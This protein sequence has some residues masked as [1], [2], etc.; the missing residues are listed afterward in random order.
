MRIFECLLASGCCILTMLGDN[1]S[2]KVKH[3]KQRADDVSQVAHLIL[4]ENL[5]VKSWTVG[6]KKYLYLSYKEQGFSRIDRIINRLKSLISWI[7]CGVPTEKYQYG[8]EAIQVT[9]CQLDSRDHSTLLFPSNVQLTY[10][11]GLETS[12]KLILRNELQE[13]M[14]DNF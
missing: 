11:S 7:K 6:E 10:A 8:G 5:C 2:K 9:G 4:V 14:C 3:A 1:K 12:I 13:K